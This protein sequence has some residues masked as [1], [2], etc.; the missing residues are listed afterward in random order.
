MKYH[1][2]GLINILAFLFLFFKA[3]SVPTIAPVWSPC[4]Q[5]QIGT[6]VLVNYPTTASTFSDTYMNI[7]YTFSWAYTTIPRVVVA[8]TKVH[9]KIFI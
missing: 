2:G 6:Y 5:I 3:S 1:N 9:C 4:Q 8:L 7:T